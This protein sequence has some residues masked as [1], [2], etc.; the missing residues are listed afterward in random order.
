MGGR[1]CVYVCGCE[2]YWHYV[3]CS[4]KGKFTVDKVV[5]QPTGEATKVKVKVRVNINGLFSV[6]SATLTEKIEAAEEPMEVDKA[7]NGPTGEQDATKVSE[8]ATDGE[9]Q[10]QQQ[11]GESKDEQ[12]SNE[13]SEEKEKT[14]EVSS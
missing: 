5:P 10:Q 12:K 11:Q 2:S 9:T 4:F 3:I 8:G 14:T 13:H 6:S 7:T 1:E